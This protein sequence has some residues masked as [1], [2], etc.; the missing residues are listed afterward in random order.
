MNW[1][2]VS[3]THPYLPTGLAP[4]TIRENTELYGRMNLQIMHIVADWRGLALRLV[5]ADPGTEE[6][7]HPQLLGNRGWF[8]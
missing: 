6:R 7:L 2:E 4:A 1:L 5:Y 3:D 8:Q